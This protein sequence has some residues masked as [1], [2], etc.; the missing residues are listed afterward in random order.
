MMMMMMMMMVMMMSI[1][2][3]SGPPT[4]PSSDMTCLFSPYGSLVSAWLPVLLVM[5]AV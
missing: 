5:V 1:F 4:H 3:H 2:G